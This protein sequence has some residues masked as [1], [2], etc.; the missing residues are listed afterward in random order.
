[1]YSWFEQWESHSLRHRLVQT[2]LTPM[3]NKI[4]ASEKYKELPSSGRLTALYNAVSDLMRNGSC[5]LLPST[6]VQVFTQS[7][8]D[9]PTGNDSFARITHLILELEGRRITGTFCVLTTKR[10]QPQVKGRHNSCYSTRLY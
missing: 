8:T 9:V 7:T 10:K 5:D 1:L 4:Q 6:Q 3:L 2:H